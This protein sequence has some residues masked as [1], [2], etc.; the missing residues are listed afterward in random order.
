MI[1]CSLT[2][3]PCLTNVLMKTALDCRANTG[4]KGAEVFGIIDIALSNSGFHA[5]SVI[6]QR[7]QGNRIALLPMLI[8]F[9]ADAFASVERIF[10]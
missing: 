2:Q 9:K 1:G 7:Q 4:N 6:L 8:V 10:S 5:T 3:V